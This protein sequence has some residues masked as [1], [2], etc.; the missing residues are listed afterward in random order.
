[1]AVHLTREVALETKILLGEKQIPSHWYNIIPDL[2]GP[3]APVE[4][5]Q[6]Q[7]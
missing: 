3:L 4:P 7:Y 1:M 6:Q 5:G 2:P